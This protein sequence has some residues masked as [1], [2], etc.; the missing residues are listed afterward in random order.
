METGLRG[1]WRHQSSWDGMK[2]EG[3]EG[4]GRRKRGWQAQLAQVLGHLGGRHG[5]VDGSLVLKNPEG[6]AKELELYLIILN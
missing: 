3:P 1:P 2:G 4:S 6:H 5:K